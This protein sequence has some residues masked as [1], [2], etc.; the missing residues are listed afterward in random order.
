MKHI[1]IIN[2][3]AGKSDKTAEYTAKIESACAGLDYEI[4]L[5]EAPGDATR[6]AR[7]AAKSGEEVRLKRSTRRTRQVQDLQRS[8]QTE[9]ASADG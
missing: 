6:F 4:R 2:P 8:L 5:T 7:E 3:A 9:P 1:F